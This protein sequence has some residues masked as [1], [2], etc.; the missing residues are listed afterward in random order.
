MPDNVPLMMASLADHP[1]AGPNWVYEIKW[2]G[3]RAICYIEDGHIRMVSRNGNSFDRQYP[4]LSVIPHNIDAENAII[5]AEIAVLDEQGR[6]R[7]ELIQPR[8]HQTNANEVAH[9]SR[10][11]P[12]KMFAFDLLYCDGYDLRNVPLIDRKRALSEIVTPGDRIQVPN[13]SP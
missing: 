8:I 13:I 5:D 4:E 9:L 3:V 11:T 6:S 7:F 12:V 10:K 1:P 2:D